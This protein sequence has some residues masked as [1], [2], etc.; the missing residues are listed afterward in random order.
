M[1]L[2][3]LFGLPGTGKTYVGKVFEK[4]FNCYFY[5]GD[6]DL[7]NEMKKAI[8]TKTVFTDQMR[9]VYFKMLISKIQ[10]LLAQA[11]LKSKIKN[12]VVAQTFIKEK[13]RIELH[14]KIPETK[15]VLVEAKKEIREKRLMERVDYPLDLEYARKMEKNFEIPKIDYLIITNNINGVEEIKRQIILINQD[16]SF[17]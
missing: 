17:S 3:I 16:H 15:F 12:L 2:I 7:T 6:N 14:K 11:S 5:D 1:S 9:D 8:K 10:N 4:Y 13:Y